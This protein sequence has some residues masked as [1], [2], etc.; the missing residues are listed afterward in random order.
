[1]WTRQG[2]THCVSVNPQSVEIQ[3]ILFRP[4]LKLK[5]LDVKRSYQ[6]GG[7]RLSLMEMGRLE[8]GFL[9]IALAFLTGE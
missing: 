9:M 5:I 8:M 3:C 2:R 7:R 6:E 4:I 1:M